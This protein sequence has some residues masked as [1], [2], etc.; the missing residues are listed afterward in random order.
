MTGSGS[1]ETCLFY[2]YDELTQQYYCDADFDEDEYDE[3]D[4]DCD[5][6][7]C[8]CDGDCETCECDCCY[9]DE[10]YYEVLCPSC[11]ETVCFDESA[12][13]EETLHCPACGSEIGA[14]YDE[15]DFEGEDEE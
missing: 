3:C 6:D 4:C 5:C 14:I 11:G 8:D 9:D 15:E 2:E 12:F 13:D 7:D 10:D 1:C